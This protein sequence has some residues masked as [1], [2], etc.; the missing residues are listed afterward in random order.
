M[1]SPKEAEMLQ[2]AWEKLGHF[3][4]IVIFMVLVIFIGTGALGGSLA[5]RWYLMMALMVLFLIAV[6]MTTNDRMDGVL[7]DWRNKMSLSRLQVII[8]TILGMSAFLVIGLGRINMI[9]DGEIGVADPSNAKDYV[10]MVG[11]VKCL[12]G[13]DDITEDHLANCPEADALEVIF[14]EELLLAMGISVASFAGSSLVKRNQSAKDGSPHIGPEKIRETRGKIAEAKRTEGAAAKK[15]EASIRKKEELEKQLEDAKKKGDPGPI[16]L[17]Q[18]KIDS[19]DDT[20][21]AEKTLSDDALKQREQLEAELKK[22]VD[23]LDKFRGLVHTNLDPS[24]AQWSDMF[25]EE[26]KTH[27]RVDISKVQ[28]FFITISVIF[29][30]AIAINSLLLN[31]DAIVNP[32]G[33]AL[34]A[35]SSSLVVL[36][37]IS[38]SGY[39]TI[40][41]SSEPA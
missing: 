6:G 27:E 40:K 32:F 3:V 25:A 13:I 7:I 4:I 36:L 20:T 21:A 29:A 11:E 33:V 17:I 10:K 28:M 16:A 5:T 1:P 18:S 19:A 37:G 15:L 38:H 35:F 23:G 22:L 41:S 39:L 26:G 14:P 30:Y 34:P 2:D 31:S 24:G 9:R 8:W 12:E